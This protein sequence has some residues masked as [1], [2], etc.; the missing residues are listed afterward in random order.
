M[1]NVGPGL[2]VVGA[3]GNYAAFTSVSKLL[4]TLLMMLG[5]IEIFAIL[6]LVLPSFWRTR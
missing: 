5:R 6:V 4:L 1:H 3:T 2:G